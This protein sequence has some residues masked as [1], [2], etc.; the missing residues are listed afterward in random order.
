[1][2]NQHDADVLTLGNLIAQVMQLPNE[3][4]PR[5]DEIGNAMV[6]YVHCDTDDELHRLTKK[7]LIGDSLYHNQ[8]LIDFV[9]DYE[10]VESFLSKPIRLS[11]AGAVCYAT[12]YKNVPKDVLCK[13]AFMVQDF[14]YYCDTFIV[15]S[16]LESSYPG[17]GR[18]LLSTLAK[19]IEVP[20]LIQAGFLHYGDYEIEAR[21]EVD[22][23][24]L[25]RL[26]A[27]YKHCGFT[28]VNDRIGNYE[29]SVTMLHDPTP[30][31]S[32][33]NKIYRKCDAT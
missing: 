15:I 6:Q 2:F 14:S 12:V 4:N 19:D 24:I 26:V 31:A 7:L 13:Q 1:M 3:I 5:C 28:V 22:S 17:S 25:D 33:L 11:N 8:M 30:N 27:I 9:L 10:G 21:D 29:A 18:S 20:I 23:G 16:G 32:V